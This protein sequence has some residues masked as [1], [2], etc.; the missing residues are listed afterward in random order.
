MKDY[1]K[2]ELIKLGPI[3][4]QDDLEQQIKIKSALITMGVVAQPK[5]IEEINKIIYGSSNKEKRTGNIGIPANWGNDIQTMIPCEAMFESNNEKTFTQDSLIEVIEKQ[6]GYHLVSEFEQFQF[7]LPIKIVP[8][9][10]WYPQQ[11]KQHTFSEFVQY[12]FGNMIA[13]IPTLKQKQFCD[14]QCKFCELE[15]KEKDFPPE[16]LEEI[17]ALEINEK[18]Q[19]DITLSG[20]SLESKDKGTMKFVKY[21]EKLKGRFGDK[22]WIELEFTPPKEAKYL[23]QLIDLGMNS[24]LINIETFN[25]KIAKEIMPKKAEIGIKHYLETI[26]YLSKKE[27]QISSLVLLGLHPGISQEQH[28]KEIIAGT[29]TLANI[30]ASTIPQP[31]KPFL[32]TTLQKEKYFPCSPQ[33]CY[34]LTNDVVK[35]L[36]ENELTSYNKG[37]HGCSGCG[38]CSLDTTIAKIGEEK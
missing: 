11:H 12:D 14:L 24:A 37:E 35:I 38:K 8:G 9:P 20:G 6:G 3:T 27:V 26:S 23:D 21:L 19:A 28:K 7:Q 18:G 31:Y 5:I 30:G 15:T 36:K 4:N 1:Y 25:E 13:S 32:G 29:K 22:L 33:L 16:I 17:I 10:S 2:K 34:E